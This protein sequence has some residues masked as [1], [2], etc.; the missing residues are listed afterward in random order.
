MKWDRSVPL[1]SKTEITVFLQVLFVLW[2][3]NGLGT[4]LSRGGTVLSRGVKL[5][6]FLCYSVK[7][8]YFFNTQKEKYTRQ[9]L[10]ILR[11]YLSK[12]TD[13]D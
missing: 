8:Y 12:Q 6:P 10:K 13:T 7:P 5:L 1:F 9:L 3:W 11:F 2:S 4:V